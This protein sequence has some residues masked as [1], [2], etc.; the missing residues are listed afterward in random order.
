MRKQIIPLI[1][2]LLVGIIALKLGHSYLTDLKKAAASHTT[3]SVKVLAATRDLPVSTL[4][5]EDH[6]KWVPVAASLVPAGACT[7]PKQVIGKALK[8]PVVTQMVLLENMLCDKGGFGGVIPKGYLAVSVKVDEYTG[9][10]GF[11]QPG[12]HVAVVGTFRVNTDRNKEETLSK[13]ILQNVEVRAV[14]QQFRENTG[15]EAKVVRSVTLLVKPEEAE[16]LQ[17]ATSLGKIFLAMEAPFDTASKSSHG[18]TL[19]TILNEHDNKWIRPDFYA[20]KFFTALFEK[21]RQGEPLR[22]GQTLTK[23]TSARG[24]PYVVELIYPD[25]F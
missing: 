21:A 10:A 7:D 6:F 22:D 9:V 5:T 1:V 14:G 17:L 25:K 23:A 13:I 8:V 16:R 24:E 20:N 12:D 18:V 2:G 3:S 4:M 15:V 19:S 11:I